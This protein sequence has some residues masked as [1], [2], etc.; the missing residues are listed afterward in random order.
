MRINHRQLEA[1]RQFMECGTVTAAAERLYVSQ[2]AMSK[3]LAALESDLGLTLFVREKKR[4]TPT[5][6]ARL[7][8]KEVRRLLSSVSNIER[9]A[10]DL[11][12]IRAG[13]L[14]IV[15]AASLGHTLVAD[16][17]EVF[18]RENPDVNVSLE[19]SSSVGQDLLAQNVDIGFSVT[20]FH[21]PAL[22]CEPLF[23]VDAVCVVPRDHPLATR[24]R[25]VPADL[26]GVDFISFLRESRMRH[27]TDAVFEQ[28]RVSR[29]LRTEVFSSAEANALVSRGLGVSIVEPINVHYGHWPRLVGIPF[30]PAIEFTFSWMR[31]RERGNARLSD[32][33]LE[34]LTRRVADIADGGAADLARMQLRLPTRASR[35]D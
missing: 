26:E 14:R 32:R 25:I 20:Q 18:A 16:A 4:L 8:Y 17:V 3:M 24:E 28:S 10:Q 7:L 31:P 22:H 13:D 35:H 2:P 11:R 33:F 30:S 9:F 34:I 5:D 23:H 21:H 1:F 19:I 29:R 27:I 15:T 6:D 12:N